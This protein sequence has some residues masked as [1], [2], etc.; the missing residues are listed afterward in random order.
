MTSTRRACLAFVAL[1]CACSDGATRIAYEIESGVAAFRRSD[2]K[3]TSI[4]H[5]PE[6]RPDG[7]AGAY[8]VQFTANSA[9]VIWCKKPDG[10]GVQGSH[11]TTYHLRFVDIPKTYKLD[12]AAGEPTIIDL[13][14]EN[15]RVVVT[16]VR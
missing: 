14:R 3:T 8:T 2:A 12:K 7:C 15:G 1:L 16:A 9:L 6:A 4:R 13:A 10:V 11:T 5:V